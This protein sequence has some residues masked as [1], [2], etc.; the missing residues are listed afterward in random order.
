M[1]LFNKCCYAILTILLLYILALT[2]EKDKEEEYK[3]HAGLPSKNKRGCKML[4]IKAR[5]GALSGLIMGSLSGGP[6]SGII[7][8]TKYG[9]VNPIVGGLSHLKNTDD[10]LVCD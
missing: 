8:A 4:Q 3:Y 10:R 5:D 7:M 1:T 2:Y 9:L 6:V